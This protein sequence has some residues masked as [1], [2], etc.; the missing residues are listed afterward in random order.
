MFSKALTITSIAIRIKSINSKKSITA[1]CFINAG[2]SPESIK[3]STAP[4]IIKNTTGTRIQEG[5]KSFI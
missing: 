5:T 2:C 1:G 4:K 3:N